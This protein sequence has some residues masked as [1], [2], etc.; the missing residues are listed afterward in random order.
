MMTPVRLLAVLV[1][2]A[3]ACKA[4]SPSPEKLP[5]APDKSQPGIAVVAPAE[6]QA[7]RPVQVVLTP[8]QQQM[9]IGAEELYQR[10]YIVRDSDP[11]RA[12]KMFRQV[13][14]RA[15]AGT[16]VREKALRQLDAMDPPAPDAAQ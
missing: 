12:R 11:E 3:A 10:A 6:P 8:E 4:E 9:E 5:A 16:A 15:P 7:I 14:D 1:V 13:A 2:L